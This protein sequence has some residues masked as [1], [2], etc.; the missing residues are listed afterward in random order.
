V[1]LVIIVVVFAA[2]VG[3]AAVDMTIHKP[4]PQSGLQ[5]QL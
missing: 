3:V 5:G 1:V 4:T 2:I